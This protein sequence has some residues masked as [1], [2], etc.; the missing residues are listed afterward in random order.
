MLHEPLER[1]VQRHGRCVQEV[2]NCV[3]GLELVCQPL[4]RLDLRQR[5]AGEAGELVQVESR[6]GLD[7]LVRRAEDDEDVVVDGHDRCGVRVVRPEDVDRLGLRAGDDLAVGECGCD[8]RL[9]LDADLDDPGPAGAATRSAD[10][11]EAPSAHPAKDEEVGRVRS[12]GDLARGD[13]SVREVLRSVGRHVTPIDC[14][15]R[16]LE[17][18]R[19]A[20]ARMSDVASVRTSPRIDVISSN[21]AWPATRGGEIWITGSPRS[22]ARQIIPASKSAFER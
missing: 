15:Q 18:P 22:S 19:Q 2:A 21:S 16:R 13:G 17:L 4:G 12:L 3:Q 7:A 5:L 1:F 11:R 9:L 10:V 6:Y 8:E 14:P 20:Q